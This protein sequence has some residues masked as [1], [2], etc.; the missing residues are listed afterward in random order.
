[1]PCACG[2]RTMKRT[3]M[4][5]IAALAVC[6]ASSPPLY[7]LDDASA[8]NLRADGK[9]EYAVNLERALSIAI[10]N[11]FELKAVKAQKKINDLAVRESW[12]D[13][14]PTL[15]L[16]YLQ[17]EEVREREADSR[18]H[19][20]GVD[21]TITIFDG[22]KRKFA[23][24]AARLKSI[25]A[26]NEYR[27]ALNS[28]IAAV[29]KA[30]LGVLQSRET[31]A[32]HE[33]TLAQGKM[34]LVFIQKELALGDATKLDALA[35]EAKVKEMELNLEKAK[36]EYL[37]RVNQFKLLLKV[38]RTAPLVIEGNIEKDFAF[39][40]PVDRLDEDLLISLALKN[41]KEIESADVEWKLAKTSL[42]MSE[43]YYLPKL[44]LGLNYNLS[45]DAFFPREKGW[46]VNIQVSS[47]LFGNS[48]SL[49]SGYTESGY[50]HSRAVSNTASA[51]ALDAMSY[52]R[53]ILESTVQYK[54]ASEK[55]KQ[56][57]REIALE[58]SSLVSS[59]K[60]SWKMIEISKRQLELYDSFLLI[61]RLKANMGESRR[62]DL[63]KKEI[64]RGEAAVAHVASLVN[65]LTASFSLE[66]AAGVDIGF[67]KLTAS[68]Q[69]KE[70]PYE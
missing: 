64:E 45:D 48:A 24:D 50:G 65:Y 47:A 2:E 57:R 7:A 12:R 6:A 33:L 62:Y 20:L 40:S 42:R 1:M 55:K 19:R 15:T 67:F 3:T 30:Y 11:N 8:K 17:T 27:V 69:K 5:L 22:G 49:N 9:S 14:F 31:I 39:L 13:F 4:C 46:G 53:A 60:N 52:K 25:L 36:D 34:Q 68:K 26:A 23:Y 29:T 10:I 70:H 51:S 41:R 38:E 66:L 59:L 37:Q 63:V 61:E 56:V 16:S 21:S 54:T 58:V 35:I 43:N 44:S 18:Q 28:F 32:I